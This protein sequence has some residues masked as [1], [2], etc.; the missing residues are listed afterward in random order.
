M[1]VF[2]QCGMIVIFFDFRNSYILFFSGANLIKK[3]IIKVVVIRILFSLKGD[4]K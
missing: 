4:L 2:C 1:N 3:K